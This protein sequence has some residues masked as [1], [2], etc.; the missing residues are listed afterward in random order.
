MIAGRRAI[1]MCATSVVTVVAV[2]VAPSVKPAPPAMAPLTAQ[3]RPAALQVPFEPGSALLDTVQRIVIP[4]SLGAPPPPAP[5]FPPEINSTSLGSTI[6]NVYNSV[7]PW[8]RYGFE[9]AT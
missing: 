6:K 9:V 4:P 5:E 8:V 1:L 2:T 7:E 3:V